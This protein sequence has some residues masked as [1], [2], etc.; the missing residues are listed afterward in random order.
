MIGP[1]ANFWKSQ[2]TK[3]QIPPVICIHAKTAN[4]SNKYWYTNLHRPILDGRR[5][6]EGGRGKTLSTGSASASSS[7]VCFSRKILLRGGKIASFT[8]LVGWWLAISCS[9]STSSSSCFSS[10]FSTL[11]F[12]KLRFKEP[13]PAKSRSAAASTPGRRF[14]RNGV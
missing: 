9:S 12:A 1:R 7:W 13:V 11:F 10:Y 3:P 8:F 2:D 6:Q 4:D 5:T 14:R